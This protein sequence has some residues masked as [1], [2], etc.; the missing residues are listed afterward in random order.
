MLLGGTDDVMLKEECQG[1]VNGASRQAQKRICAGGSQ[2]RR[3]S[4]GEDVVRNR[5]NQG[6][7]MT[8]IRSETLVIL[9]EWEMGVE[10]PGWKENTGG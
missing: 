9:G 6:G 2:Q 4:N 1:S 8:P 7:K 3:E 5:S 10:M